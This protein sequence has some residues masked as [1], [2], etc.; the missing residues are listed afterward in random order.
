MDSHHVR[1]VEHLNADPRPLQ[2]GVII[3]SP[4][5]EITTKPDSI[6]I[7]I[8]TPTPTSGTTDPSQKPPTL[9]RSA[10]LQKSVTEETGQVAD[11][12]IALLVEVEAP[13]EPTWQ[14]AISSIDK[15]KWLEGAKAELHSLEEMEV[16]KLIPH[17]AVPSDRKVLHGKFICCLKRDEQGNPMRHKVQWVLPTNMGQRFY[18]YNLTHHTP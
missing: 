4:S 11:L 5:D 8:P 3:N 18:E 16:F 7:Q 15:D 13:N 10:C 12:E 17:S 1:F 14:E 2:P 9:R 6:P